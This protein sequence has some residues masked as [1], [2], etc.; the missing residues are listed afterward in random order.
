MKPRQDH[1]ADQFEEL[2]SSCSGQKPSAE[3]RSVVPDDVDTEVSEMVT[4][5]R[6]LQA[7][8]SLVAD[9]AFAQRLERKMLA[10]SIQHRQKRAS[11]ANRNWLFGRTP[12]VWVTF[13]AF[14]LFVLS[15]AGT[16]LAMA[17]GV[18]NPEDPLYTVKV[19]EQHVQL[20]LASSPENRID[21]S[22]Q[23]IRD[24]LNTAATVANTS[25]ASTYHQ[26]IEDIE[27]Q[28]DDASQTINKL[29]AGSDQQR[30][31]NELDSLKNDVRQTLYSFL[32]KLPFT[33][34]LATTTFLGHLGASVPSIQQATV[35]V[36][37]HPVEQATIT[38]TGN[39]FTNSTH[40]MIN[41]QLFTGNCTV[42]SNTCVFV[43]PWHD[44][45][46]PDALAVLNED[47]TIAQTRGITFVH[48][49]ENNGNN[50][51]NQ[52]DGNSNDKGN[53]GNTDNGHGHNNPTDDAKPT[54]TP[55]PKPTSTPTPRR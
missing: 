49:D 11:R 42:Q 25:H 52:N 2:L 3:L 1:R 21:V 16:V 22:L 54:S 34:Q 40:L 37:G 18:S 8:P 38:V 14:L 50:G 5:A 32:P 12:R 17:S 51:N 10:H 43:I 39:N 6:H 31:S 24:R 13:A 33:E 47:D 28:I 29:P 46:A 19:W 27:Q 48:T 4:L 23:I 41:G 36:T 26:T 55:Q 44:Q 30:L 45:K 7:S 15:G 20:A 53:N 9:P 35:T